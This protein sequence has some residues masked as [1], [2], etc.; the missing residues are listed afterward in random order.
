MGILRVLKSF[1][2]IFTVILSSKYFGV[3]VERDAWVIGGTLVASIGGLLFGP[4]TI[5]FRT[6]FINIREES[7][8]SHAIK[9]ASD[10][11]GGIIFVSILIILSIELYPNT[12]ASF[13]A[14]GYNVADARIVINMI[15]LLLP[16]LLINQLI[17][18]WTSVLN[19]YNSFLIPD[20]FSFFSFLGFFS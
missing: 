15:R 18:I 8:E 12:I 10:L 2:A 5:I 17:I 4:I 14:P 3:T 9:S 11:I 1:L 13:I 19:S 16:S 6:M 7:G 20:F